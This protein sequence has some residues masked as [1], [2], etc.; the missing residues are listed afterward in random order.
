M[1]LGLQVRNDIAPHIRL[2]STAAH[3]FGAKEG[4]K[5]AVALALSCYDTTLAF[6]NCHLAANNLGK[7][8]AQ[9]GRTVRHEP[10]HQHGSSG[11]L[12]ATDFS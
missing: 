8:R 4:S 2:Q 3:S 12:N 5:G 1:V 10:P 9:Y 6:I 11:I 7:R